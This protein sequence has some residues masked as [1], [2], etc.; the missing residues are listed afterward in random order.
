MAGSM[1]GSGLGEIGGSLAPQGRFVQPCI[2]IPGAKPPFFGCKAD[3]SGEASA[4]NLKR[5]WRMITEGS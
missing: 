3:I 4:R 1:M 2:F 5:C